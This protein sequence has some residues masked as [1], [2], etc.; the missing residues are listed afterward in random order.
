MI[1]HIQGQTFCYEELKADEV[2]LKS[3][4]E[5]D[6]PLCPPPGLDGVEIA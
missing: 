1:I 2:C 5:K 6:L 3:I 4:D